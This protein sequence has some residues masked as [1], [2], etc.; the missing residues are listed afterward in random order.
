MPK[1]ITI[2]C[3]NGS[4]Y[5]YYK[6]ELIK[7]NVVMDMIMNNVKLAELNTKTVSAVLNKQALKMI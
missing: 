2:I 3:H 5:E 6:K 1:D 4:T 7:S